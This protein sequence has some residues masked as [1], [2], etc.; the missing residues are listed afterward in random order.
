[1]LGLVLGSISSVTFGSHHAWLICKVV[2]CYLAWNRRLPL[3]LMPLLDD[4]HRLGLMRAIGPLY[5]FRHAEFQDHL[6]SG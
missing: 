4:M 1:M 5:Q 3:A 6:R 2:L